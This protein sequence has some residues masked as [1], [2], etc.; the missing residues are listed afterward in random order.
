[1]GVIADVLEPQRAGIVDQQ[2]EDAPARRKVPDRPVRLGVDAGGDEALEVLPA[3]VEDTD[4][5]IAR[6]GELARDIEELL[7]HGLDVE[8]GDQGSPRVD[9]AAE[10]EFVEDG[11]SAHYWRG[12][13][14]LYGKLLMRQ[15]VI[16]LRR[17]V[18]RPPP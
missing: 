2:S 7:Q 16:G 14:P 5:R 18:L 13:E 6:A 11:R 3:L 10:A 1:M 8:R 17:A 4:R 15:G 9:Q 12:S